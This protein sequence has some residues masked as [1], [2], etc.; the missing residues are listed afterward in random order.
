MARIDER[1][2]AR[3]AYEGPWEDPEYLAP[4]DVSVA[5]GAK[6]I[7]TPTRC[8]D[9]YV[10][11]SE[12]RVGRSKNRY[13]YALH[14]YRDGEV[15]SVADIAN[16][17]EP[18]IDWERRTALVFDEQNKQD[19][20]ELDLSSGEKTKLVL[21]GIVRSRLKGL[22]HLGRDHFVVSRASAW[23]ETPAG[24]F[25][26]VFKRGVGAGCELVGEWRTDVNEL[27]GLA[28]LE[29]RVLVTG[30]RR[31]VALGW[32]DG[33]MRVLASLRGP[34]AY[35]WSPGGDV[36]RY[37]AEGKVYEVRGALGVWDECAE[38]KD[39]FELYRPE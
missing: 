28:V 20:A 13:R 30:H 7:A 22:A 3:V 37:Y 27:V 16:S 34:V 36:V 15:G 9:G 38:R 25:L 8:G 5:M 29:G 17:G 39:E 14:W 35:P 33:E 6:L 1:K 11:W 31:P 24:D 32:V 2:V 10:G 18:S 26:Y 12:K 19:V 4:E 21:E 23:E